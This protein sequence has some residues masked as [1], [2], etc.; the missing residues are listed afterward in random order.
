LKAIDETKVFEA[1]FRVDGQ[2]L[3]EDNAKLI[4]KRREAERRATAENRLL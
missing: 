2:G 4:V 3:S 1:L